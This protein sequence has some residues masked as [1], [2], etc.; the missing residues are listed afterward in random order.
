MPLAEKDRRASLPRAEVRT[1]VELTVDDYSVPA[2]WCTANV[3]MGGMFVVMANPRP[4]GSRAGNVPATLRD[5]TRQ[6]QCS[7]GRAT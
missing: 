1:T 2:T 5:E 3:S 4:V 7:R 6:I